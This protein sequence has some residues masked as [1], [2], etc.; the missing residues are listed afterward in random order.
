MSLRGGDA[1]VTLVEVLVALSIIAVMA[2][3]SVLALRTGPGDSPEAEARK[4][5]IRLAFAVDEALSTG[6]PLRFETGTDGYRFTRP[7]D[8]EWREAGLARLKPRSLPRGIA[9]AEDP[10]SHGIGANGFGRPF[11]LTLR[12]GD[13]PW[14]VRFDGLDAVAEEARR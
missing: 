14:R 8:G 4:L 10:A 7:E 1:G 2:S 12:D 11:S 13:R 5:A 9:F 3:A 6:T